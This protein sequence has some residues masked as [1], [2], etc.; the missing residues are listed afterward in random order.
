MCGIAGFTLWKEFTF[1]VPQTLAAMTDALTHRGPDDEGAYIDAGV[2]LG[3][4][5]LSIIDLVSGKMPIHNEDQS[6]WIVFNGEIYNFPELRAELVAK[7]HIFLTNTDT[8]VILHLYEE[9]RENCVSRLN[10]MFALAIWDTQAQALFLARDRLGIKP[11]HYLE[12]PGGIIFASEI[13]AILKH[14]L[15]E[16]QL[17]FSALSKYLTYDYIP[18]P[19]SLLKGIQKLGPGH[20]LV[21]TRKGLNIRQYW[22]LPIQED[23]ISYKR[24]EEHVEEVVTRLRESVRKRLISDVPVGVLLS[25][26]IDSS[27]VALFAAQQYPG[28]IQSF[29]IGFEEPS[30]DES[31]YAQKIA[32]LI[33]ADHHHQ[34]LSSQRMLEVIPDVIR[35]LDEPM[36]DASIIPT[37]LL[38][39]MTAQFVKVALG[40]DGADELFAGYP[41]YQAHKLVTYYSVLPYQ[42]REL[43]NRMAQRLPVSHRNI[44]FDFKI[45]QFL[46]G[47]GVSS[48]I[49]FF[50]WMGAFLEQEKRQL[51]S[52]EA[53][54]Q[55]AYTN[56]FEDIIQ[57]V[58]D[59]KLLKEFE[60]ILYLMMK[61]YLQDD[62]L[63]KVDRASMAH[64]LEVRVPFL[65]YTFVEYVAGLPT[66][67][68]LRGLTTKYVLKKA[69]QPLL[70]KEIV[71]RKKKGFGIPL[72]Q[73][74]NG[75][76]K[77]LLLTYLDAERI[78]KA[79]I[80]N[81]AYI[82]RLLEEHFAYKSDHRKQLWPLLVFEMWREQY[83]K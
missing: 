27:A 43:I 73:W 51:F 8:E 69:M 24:E 7:G 76:L 5:R 33:G 53:W 48:E 31:R 68:K 19:H 3:S 46:K 37:Y 29:S 44:S 12:Y 30:F 40:G 72:A 23:G 50:L 82:S 71:Y 6:L 39:Q 15:V 80:F 61:L 17:D 59:S 66:I 55:L 1:D 70:P 78:R 11:L 83:L 34:V 25:G 35:L 13:K 47:M 45:K 41:T 62:I 16:P 18:A 42:I 63:V 77:D 10:G 67:Y 21:C 75:P 81:Y 65:D 60:R 79:G 14:P 54:E 9:H 58:R 22:D 56:P 38:S 57:Y 2:A 4:R 64:S 28:R 49:R 36:A 20:V 74:L 52:P 32:R 26:G